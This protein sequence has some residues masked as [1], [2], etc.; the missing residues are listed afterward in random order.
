MLKETRCDGVMVGRGA[1]GRPWIFAEIKA[2]QNGETYEPPTLSERLRIALLHAERIEAERGPHGLVELRKHLPRYLHGVGNGA[3]L[4]TR[5]N[6]AN[7]AAEI[8]QIL[9]DSVKDITI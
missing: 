2:A 5:L 1:L 9:L 7:S 6:A 4:R 3:A 8:R